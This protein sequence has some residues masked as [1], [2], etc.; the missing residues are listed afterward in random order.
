MS[1]LSQEHQLKQQSGCA[2]A[3]LHRGGDSLEPQRSCESQRSVSRC[4]P[5]D[6]L[7]EMKQKVVRL[8][9]V[10]AL[11]FTPLHSPSQ[12]FLAGTQPQSC[13]VEGQRLGMSCSAP[14]TSH[15]LEDGVGFSEMLNSCCLDKSGTPHSCQARTSAQ[16]QA[17]RNRGSC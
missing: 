3:C 4:V 14:A 2:P 16:G 9:V 12:N 5:T 10:L 17:V 8:R 7:K 11:A 15:L 13:V 1:S 6:V